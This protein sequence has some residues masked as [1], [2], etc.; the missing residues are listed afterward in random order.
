LVSAQIII[1]S[2]AIIGF[3][4]TGGIGK[5]KQ[6]LAI[7]R[8]DFNVVRAKTTDFV[9]DIKNKTDSGMEGKEG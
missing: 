2:I 3:F 5:T 9:N 8:T 4:A 7:A 6:A 1:L